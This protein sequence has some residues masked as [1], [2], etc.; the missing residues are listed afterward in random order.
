MGGRIVLWMVWCSCLIGISEECRAFTPLREEAKIPAVGGMSE[1][2]FVVALEQ[3]SDCLEGGHLAIAFETISFDFLHSITNKKYRPITLAHTRNWVAKYGETFPEAFLLHCL[4]DGEMGIVSG[5]Y[6]SLGN[7]VSRN[8]VRWCLLVRNEPLIEAP[9]QAVQGHY[10]T[11]DRE[12]WF[13]VPARVI[14]GKRISKLFISTRIFPVW[15]QVVG[16]S[17]VMTRADKVPVPWGNG[18]LPDME[19]YP[20]TAPDD[21]LRRSILGDSVRRSVCFGRRAIPFVP[22]VRA[23]FGVLKA[24]EPS[25]VWNF[26]TAVYSPFMSMGGQVV[27]S[28]TSGKVDGSFHYLTRVLVSK[29]MFKKDRMQNAKQDLMLSP[30]I[31]FSLAKKDGDLLVEFS[32]PGPTIALRQLT[33]EEAL[34]EARLGLPPP[35]YEMYSHILHRRLLVKGVVVLLVVLAGVFSEV[36]RRNRKARRVR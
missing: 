15:N 1:D 25:R 7:L 27:S 30:P 28:G 21:W 36:V 5:Q 18:M 4:A 35:G 10:F 14:D 32:W 29:N 33:F 16:E 19:R 24:N 8:C 22:S 9:L 3:V 2:E 12:R 23:G 17:V 26:F 31:D 6:A 20:F 11:N 34:E 13:A